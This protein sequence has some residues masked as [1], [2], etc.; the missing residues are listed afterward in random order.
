MELTGKARESFE[1]WYLS[2][3][4]H[5]DSMTVFDSGK[6]NQ[7]NYLPDNMKWGVYVDFFDSEGYEI[8][9]YKDA[10]TWDIDV[11]DEWKQ[12]NVKTRKEAREIAV[13]ILYSLYNE[14]NLA[15]PK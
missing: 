4:K 15:T 5:Y 6:I 12:T 9:L 8:I 3:Q 14:I 1:K 2:N 10:G 7:F 13:K 11:N